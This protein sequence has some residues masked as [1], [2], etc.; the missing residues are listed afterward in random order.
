MTQQNSQILYDS[1][2]AVPVFPDYYQLSNILVR[3]EDKVLLLHRSTEP[4]KG[5]WSVPGGGVN[6]NEKYID[7]AQR[8]LSEETGLSFIDLE[9]LYIYVDHVHQ[10]ES[11][12]YTYTSL[13]G[14]FLNQEPHEHDIVTW[15]GVN[16]AM[17]LQLTPGVLEALKL[18]S[19]L[20]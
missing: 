10:L 8:E 14:E 15:K 20:R 18:L 5:F 4:F 3:W 16:D 7:T 13:D 19:Q 9:P 11:H 6:T 2:L 17:K 12:I 1:D